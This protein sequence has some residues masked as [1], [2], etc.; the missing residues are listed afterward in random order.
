MA[1]LPIEEHIVAACSSSTGRRPATDPGTELSVALIRGLADIPSGPQRAKEC[2]VRRAEVWE[3]IGQIEFILRILEDAAESA[4]D[5][6]LLG[7][8]KELQ[9]DRL[10][11][12]SEMTNGLQRGIEG[13]SCCDTYEA[14]EEEY[15]AIATSLDECE[16]RVKKLCKLVLQHEAQVKALEQTKSEGEAS[17][18]WEVIS[19]IGEMMSPMVSVLDML[20]APVVIQQ[21]Q[22]EIRQQIADSRAD[23]SRTGPSQASSS[24]GPRALP[25]SN[26]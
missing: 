16:T 19:G 6:G 22:A 24:G 2:A 5:N 23:T 18:P 21:H 13:L 10:K 12:A 26:A 25:P 1:K 15:E 17:A 9:T 11:W 3:A 7:T 14:P 4:G 20:K 8:E